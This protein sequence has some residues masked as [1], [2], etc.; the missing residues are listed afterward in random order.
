MGLRNP[1]LDKFLPER[2]KQQQQ[3][4]P[5]QPAQSPPA[6]PPLQ[7]V[8]EPITDLDI[9]TPERCSLTCSANIH[10]VVYTLFSVSTAGRTFHATAAS[11]CC[12]RLAALL[13]EL[14]RRL[15]AGEVVYLHCWGGRGRAGTVGATL[16]HQ[17]SA[18]T[19]RRPWSGCS[20]PTPPAT[21]LRVSAKHAGAPPLPLP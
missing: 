12:R 11:A 14:E 7:F 19:R 18:W 21:T 9:P 20:T 15:R 2:R 17:L 5:Q 4:Q 1:Y 16:L 6:P 13:G 10:A 8:H 3:Q